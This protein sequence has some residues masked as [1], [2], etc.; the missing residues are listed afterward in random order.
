MEIVAYTKN[1]ENYFMDFNIAD[2]TAQ[3]RILMEIADLITRRNDH[4]NTIENQIKDEVKRR[5]MASI[6]IFSKYTED[7][8]FR[9]AYNDYMI[10]LFEESSFY[11]NKKSLEVKRR[12]NE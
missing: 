8:A 10:E 3:H 7:K 11:E 2:G 1:Y 12:N 6:E 9:C 5:M 4:I